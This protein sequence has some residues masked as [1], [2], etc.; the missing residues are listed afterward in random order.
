MS[1][2]LMYPVMRSDHTV[3]AANNQE[4]IREQQSISY[5]ATYL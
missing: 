5:Q 2:C 1:P 3:L 4:E